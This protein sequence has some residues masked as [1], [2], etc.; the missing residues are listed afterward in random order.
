MK[1][2]IIS[3]ALIVGVIFIGHLMLQN[4]LWIEEN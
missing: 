4:I 1:Y 3:V 2:F